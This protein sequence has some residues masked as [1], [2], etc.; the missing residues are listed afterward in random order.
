VAQVAELLDEAG[1][2]DEFIVIGPP[3]HLYAHY[4]LDA[5]GIAAEA[6]GALG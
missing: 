3:T 2:R 5:A 4:R 6:R 1:I